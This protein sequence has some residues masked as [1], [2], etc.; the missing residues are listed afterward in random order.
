MHVHVAARVALQSLCLAATLSLAASGWGFASEPEFERDI[1]PI[2]KAYCWHCHG[3]EPELGGKLDARLVRTL[4]AGGESGPAVVATKPEE[5]S[6]LKRVL[7]DEMPPTDKKLN[8]KQK[9][10]IEEWIRAGA[11]HARPEP[12]QLPIGEILTDDDRN[13]WAFQPAARPALPVVSA[14]DQCVTPIDYFILAKLESVGQSFSAEADRRTLVRRVSFDLTGLPPTPEEVHVCEQDV[15]PDWYERYVDRLLASPAYA[16]RWARHWLDV[17]GYADSNGYTEK[18]SPREWSWK[19][20]DYVV[21]AFNEDMPWDRFIIEQLAGDELVTHSFDSL[22]EADAQK[23]I[24][25]AYLRLVPDGTGEGGVNAKEARNDTI[26][27]TVKVVSSSLL[28]LTVGCAQ[29]HSHRYDPITHVDYYR[30]RAVLAPALN[31]ETWKKPQERLV[32]LWSAETRALAETV[33]AEQARLKKEREAA[34]DALVAETFE[35]ELTKLPE[36]IREAARTARATTAKERTAEQKELIKQYPFLNVDRGSV[37]LYLKDRQKGFNKHWDEL[38]ATSLAK[39]PAEDFVYAVTEPEAAPPPTHLFS[40]GD[41]NQPREVVEAEEFE[42][43]RRPDRPVQFTSLAKSF[44]ESSGLKNPKTS[45]L[46]LGYARYLTSGEHPLVARVLTNRFWMHFFG[47]GLVA[48]TGDFGFQGDRPSHPELLD[49]LAR[50][51]VDGGWELKAWQRL[52][53]TSRVY[54]Q[55][56]IKN[57]ALYQLDPDNRLLGRMPLRRM[58]SEMMRDAVLHTSKQLSG[59]RFGKPVPVAPDEVGQFILAKDNRDSAG[60]PE[61]KQADLGEEAL[62]RT[63]YVQVRRSMPLSILEPFDHPVMAPNCEQRGQS[64]VPTQSLVLMNSQFAANAAEAMLKPMAAEAGDDINARIRWAFQRIWL[65]DPTAE[66]L[67]GARTLVTASSGDASSDSKQPENQAAAQEEQDACW[68]ALCHA[69]LCSTR[70]VVI[71]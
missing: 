48:T 31:M 47:K 50:Q 21:R 12:E 27:E 29:C 62:R 66:E 46:R 68:T 36:E 13:H 9:Q 70:Y 35:Q 10:M 64:T 55:S 61:G 69:L 34:L 2:L 39:R 19:Y 54:R 67:A 25:T 14:S 23:L 30:L 8:L 59:K 42:V 38:Q 7:S 65:R 3:E 63:I 28:G 37:Y 24:A 56:S 16:E 51:F 49:W 40:R 43:L 57:A 58:E 22:D 15:A 60:R 44:A 33:D 32:S 1:R 11:K 4:L 52:L 26:A 53:V 45:G 20:R 5:S 71:E 6:L 41:F 18:D 17:V